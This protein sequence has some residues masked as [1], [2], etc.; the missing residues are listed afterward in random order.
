[1]VVEGSVQQ[2]AQSMQRS[3]NAEQPR[4]QSFVPRSPRHAVRMQAVV[5]SGA[6]HARGRVRDMSTSGLFVEADAPLVVGQ[7]VTVLS[8]AGERDGERRP[9]EVARVV[10]VGVG[11][12]FLPAN[13]DAT[14]PSDAPVFVLTDDESGAHDRPQMLTVDVRASLKD[15]LAQVR[16]LESENGQLT[17]L[18][19]A[20]IRRVQTL[21]EL[22]RRGMV[23]GWE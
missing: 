17:R 7:R 21:E 3:A 6:C 9:A 4:A 18:R 20:L 22:L 11:L 19:D 5:D 16:L 1:V 23:D 13:E 12:R 10:D 8:L 14:T 15:A 2:S